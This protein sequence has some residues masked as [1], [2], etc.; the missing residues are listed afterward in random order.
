VAFALYTEANAIGDQYD[1]EGEEKTL[2][3]EVELLEKLRS[4][5]RVLPSPIALGKRSA[6]SFQ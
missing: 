2:N 3:R 4:A 5:I 1:W 6:T